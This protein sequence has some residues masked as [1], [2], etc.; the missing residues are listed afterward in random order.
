MFNSICFVKC[1]FM[2]CLIL[3][4]SVCSA[5][6]FA[7]SS[8]NKTWWVDSIC[9][10]RANLPDLFQ[11]TPVMPERDVQAY[12]DYYGLHFP[13]KE[14]YFGKFESQGYILTGQ[15]FVPESPKA[16]I[17]ILHGYLDHCAVFKNLISLLIRHQYAVGIYDM[18]GHGFSSGE[19]ASIDDF[20]VY[21]AI[22]Q[23]FQ[24]LCEKRF[25]G[26]FHLIAH[27]TGCSATID[28]ILTNKEK[29][30][31]NKIIL[32]AP[33]IRSSAWYLSKASTFILSPFLNRLPRLFIKNSSDK[34]FLE[35]T[36]KNDPLQYRAVVLKWT[37]ALFAWNK[38]LKKPVLSGQSLQ[39]I[40]VIQG[41]K[42]KIV[43]WKYNLKMIN[44]KFP[45]SQ[46]TII[47][48]AKHHLVNEAIKFKKQV[49]NLIL[50]DLKRADSHG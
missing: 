14:H 30:K 13:C 2:L 33:L 3:G 12:F 45:M 36:K 22:L 35:F 8:S 32:L 24:I 11:E 20:H 42:D 6:G 7:A 39:K 27:S 18:P 4:V 19:K 49:F 5:F 16:F 23:D 50:D 29:V 31:F 41:S 38:D 37:K 46:I 40:Y 34:K 25:Q 48:G 47:K 1:F 26:T 9:E 43:D 10:K 17:V 21:S 28:Y 15:I 44:K